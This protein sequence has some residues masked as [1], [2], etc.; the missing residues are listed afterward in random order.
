MPSLTTA[1][2]QISGIAL[3]LIALSGCFEKKSGTNPSETP[4]G[5]MTF[6]T[7]F[8]TVDSV[9]LEST[10]AAPIARISGIAVDSGGRIIIADAS[11]RT[12]RIY[13]SQGELLKSLGR[14]GD[15]PGEFREPR[16]VVALPGSELLIGEGGG[17]LHRYRDDTLLYSVQM[18]SVSFISSM[19]LARPGAIVVSTGDQRESSIV[20]LNLEGKFQRRTTVFKGIPVGETPEDPR[21][22]SV[23]QVW[24]AAC[25]STLYAAATIG[26]SIWETDSVGAM[27]RSHKVHYQGYSP[28]RLPSPAS[29]PNRARPFESI[30]QYDVVQGLIC[31]PKQVAFT[32]VRGVR[33]YGDP[34][35]LMIRRGEQWS[36]HSSGPPVILLR[37]DTLYSLLHPGSDTTWIGKHVRR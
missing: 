22:Q 1:L 32:Y 6:S 3:A 18:D 7:G 15:G 4:A 21:W 8:L 29:P 17:R 30:K 12:V 2:V 19:S 33:N 34:Q 36:A 5:P 13:S 9:R 26:D 14:T 10:D 20:E 16:Y 35:V 31:D 11:E 25:G 27:W 24:A 28:P 37:S 23:F